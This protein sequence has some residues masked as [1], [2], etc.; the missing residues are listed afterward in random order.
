MKRF[1]PTSL[2]LL[3]CVLL[4]AVPIYRSSAAG[5]AIFTATSGQQWEYAELLTGDE[6][7][8]KNPLFMFTTG[9][10]YMG[11]STAS[12][13]LKK[14]GGTT[15]DHGPTAAKLALFDHLGSKGW[16]LVSVAPEGIWG[17][18]KDA[19]SAQNHGY[20]RIYLFKRPAVK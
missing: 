17:S 8:T 16:E 7:L 14:L 2:L 9:D 10:T 12:G 1:M 6:G 4:V 5:P 15:V 18:Q 20:G 19:N 11:E 13:L 3:A